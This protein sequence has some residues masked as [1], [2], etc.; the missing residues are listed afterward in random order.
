[1]A[2]MTH[3]VNHTGLQKGISKIQAY[4]TTNDEDAG[5][6]LNE[7]VSLKDTIRI[8]NKR[9]H[10]KYEEFTRSAKSFKNNNN[11]CINALN[12]VIY[13]YFKSKENSVKIIRNEKEKI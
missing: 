13:L 2:N 1:M 4:I 3:Y 7:L 12:H 9:I 8:N 5:S 10:N 11:S 6:I